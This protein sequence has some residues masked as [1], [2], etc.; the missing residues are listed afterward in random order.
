MVNDRGRD[1]ESK[2]ELERSKI[3]YGTHM[4]RNLVVSSARWFR[5]AGRR[6]LLLRLPPLV[7]ILYGEEETTLEGQMGERICIV[8]MG[9]K[10]GDA[11][12][13]WE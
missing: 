10:A 1:K 8:C 11:G 5:S 13:E 2:Y 3:G 7:D 12:L 4:H 6:H 9:A